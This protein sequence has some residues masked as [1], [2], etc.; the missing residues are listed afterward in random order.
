MKSHFCINE[1]F[2]AVPVGR[3]YVFDT[4]SHISGVSFT[5][6]VCKKECVSGADHKQTDSTDRGNSSVPLRLE[7]QRCFWYWLQCVQYLTSGRF[8]IKFLLW[9]DWLRYNN[10]FFYRSCHVEVQHSCTAACVIC[11][12]GDE[13]VRREEP[14]LFK[15]TVRK[16]IVHYFLTFCRKRI[17]VIRNNLLAI[18]L[19]PW[20]SCIEKK[21]QLV[22]SICIDTFQ[23]AFSLL[24]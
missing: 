8:I 23:S 9:T 20:K 5:D 4:A 10:R 19:F 2:A 15:Q 16:G 17:I 18:S 14:F 11:G 6:Q 3:F 12:C 7:P 1:V 22:I 24:A 13:V 21:H